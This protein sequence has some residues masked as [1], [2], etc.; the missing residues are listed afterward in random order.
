[1]V[2]AMFEGL[3]AVVTGGGSGIGLATARLLRD[4]GARVAAVDLNPPAEDGLS[5]VTGDVTDQASVDAAISQVAAEFGGIDILINNAGIGSVGTVVDNDDEE[6]HRCWD[7]NVVG[8]A[9][10]MRAA[11]PYLEQSAHPA[12]VNT[13]S[14]A[15]P[16]GIVQRALYTATKG[17]VSSLTRA[18]AADHLAAGIRVNSVDP[19]T[20][21]TPWVQRLLAAADDP[22]TALAALEARQPTGRLVTPEEVAAAIVHLASPEASAT[23]GVALSVDGGMA[24]L[25]LPG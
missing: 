1:M 24:N 17:A 7:V 15:A 13:G 9:R 2:T 3:T 14:I 11:L 12:V 21:D 16:T 8:I 4:R 22:D 19:G 5:G 23:T 25:R 6:W 10:M 18:M 20:A